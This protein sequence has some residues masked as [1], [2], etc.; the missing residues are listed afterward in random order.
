MKAVTDVRNV[1]SKTAVVT[2]VEVRAYVVYTLG[3]DVA[4]LDVSVE[5]TERVLI[6]NAELVIP[7]ELEALEL[8]VVIRADAEAACVVEGVKELLMAACLAEKLEGVEAGNRVELGLLEVA[9]T[10]AATV[11]GTTTALLVESWSVFSKGVF[12]ASCTFVE[13]SLV[14]WVPVPEGGLGTTPL[15][16]SAAS[17]EPT[18]ALPVSRSVN[19]ILVVPV[20]ADDSVPSPPASIVSGP[21]SNVPRDGIR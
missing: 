8:I 14:G 19:I 3:F 11:A 21:R 15:P 4:A 6:G 16:E 13:Y 12:D 18:M 9:T 7:S 10:F 1:V 20:E 17:E 5:E 2:G